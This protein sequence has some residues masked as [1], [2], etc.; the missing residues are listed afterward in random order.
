MAYRADSEYKSELVQHVSAIIC[1]MRLITLRG[2][3]CEMNRA[4]WLEEQ[5]VKKLL[6]DPLWAKAKD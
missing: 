1:F 3:L 2:V 5:E 6:Q 4:L